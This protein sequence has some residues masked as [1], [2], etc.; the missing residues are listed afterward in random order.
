MS[1]AGDDLLADD[2]MISWLAFPYER[3]D[4]CE[5]WRPRSSGQGEGQEVE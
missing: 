5:Q 2:D 4:K 1:S 3:V